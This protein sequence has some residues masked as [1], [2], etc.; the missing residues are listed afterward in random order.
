MAVVT[1]RTGKASKIVGIV[2]QW[3]YGKEV[4]RDAVSA[5]IAALLVDE[6]VV[7]EPLVFPD[8]GCALDS[9]G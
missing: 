7:I 6:Y 4:R 3:R 1:T 2:R 8:D 9:Y 5:G